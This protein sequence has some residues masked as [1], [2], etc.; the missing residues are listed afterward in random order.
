MEPNQT[1]TIDLQVWNKTQAEIERLSTA[2][3][4]QNRKILC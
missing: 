2:F 1:I 3:Y 4:N